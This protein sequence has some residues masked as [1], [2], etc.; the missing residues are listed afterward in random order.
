MDFAGTAISY[1]GAIYHC[2]QRS[3]SCSNA[4]AEQSDST[5]LSAEKKSEENEGKPRPQPVH[6]D[7]YNILVHLSTNDK[8]AALERAEMVF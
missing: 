5:H 2:H 3:Q 8:L 4:S 7:I 1:L 6:T